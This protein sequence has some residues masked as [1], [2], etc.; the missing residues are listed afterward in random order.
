LKSAFV[1]PG[2]GSQSPG[3]M[4]TFAE[5]APVVRET[6]DEASA[7]LGYDL[8]QLC[9]QGPEEELNATERTQPAMLVAGVAT[10]RAWRARG[11][12]IPDTMTGHSLGEITALVCAG[13][14]KFA[15]AVELV[16][17]RG[18]AMQEAVPAGQGAMAAVL[19][20]DDQTVESIC[21][22]A[23]DGGVVVPA[24]FNSPGQ[25]VIAGATPAVQ[26]AAEAAKAKG[27]RRAVL[28]PISVP[29]HSPLLQPAA[30]RLRE[31]LL[32]LDIQAPTLPVLAFDASVYDS[33]QSIRTGLY[34]Q[35]YSPVRWTSIV[36][37]MIAD[38][39]THVVE[40]GPGKVLAGLV[41]RAEGGRDLNIFAVDTPDSLAT[42]LE[43]LGQEAA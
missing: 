20:L 33:A 24:N 21:A 23:A 40:A 14:F 38:G 2:Q 9:Q 3:M 12:K 37:A 25:V 27:A 26:R 39:I 22:D 30:E 1:F 35:L 11:G 18:R 6:F 43:A 4:A 28:L 7:V 34:H 17:F 19:G 29:C 15:D 31:R 10:W 16:R 5:S 13:A 42:T 32:T 41:R 36:A 8:W